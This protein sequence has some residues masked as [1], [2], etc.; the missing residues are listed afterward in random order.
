MKNGI[1][2]KTYNLINRLF[3]LS[4]KIIILGIFVRI[5]LPNLFDGQRLI[6]FRAWANKFIIIGF[7]LL[8][9]LVGIEI[10]IRW[11]DKS[12][13][14]FF[15]SIKQTTLIRQY[16]KQYPDKIPVKKSGNAEEEIEKEID[17]IT[18]DFNQAVSK[19]V[20]DVR[21]KTV[22]LKIPIPKTQQAQALLKK[23]NNQILEEIASKNEEYYFS[24]SIR[25][26]NNLF[27]EG[28]RR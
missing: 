24:K 6:I 1:Y 10:V 20:V 14:N 13:K 25:V 9:C 27:F 21:K 15:S 26:K 5:I 18:D 2:V 3:F 22:L 4:N 28:N 19:S 12:I 16:I 11:G 23:M 17:P 7:L 8:I